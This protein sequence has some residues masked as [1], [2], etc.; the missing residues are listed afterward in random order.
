V[1][2]ERVDD[3]SAQEQEELMEIAVQ[4]A[5]AYFSI[6]ED[7]DVPFALGVLCFGLGRYEDAVSLFE[8]SL[9]LHGPDPATVQNLAMC[10]A[11]LEGVDEAVSAGSPRA[12]GSES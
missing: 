5:G 7:E 1:L 12:T 3:A 4:V 10:R 8:W 9:M 6:G 11:E 2:I